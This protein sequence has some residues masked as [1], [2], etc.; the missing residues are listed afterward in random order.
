[1]TAKEFIN[2]LIDENINLNIANV[3]ITD[4]ANKNAWLVD[5]EGIKFNGG[6]IEI[7]LNKLEDGYY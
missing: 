4:D 3:Y 2:V 5:F 7:K 6:D 1:M